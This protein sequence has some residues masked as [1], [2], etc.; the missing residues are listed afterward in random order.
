VN[1]AKNQLKVFFSF[2][3]F[4]MSLNALLVLWTDPYRVWNQSWVLKTQTHMNFYL[5]KF[6]LMPQS[7]EVESIILGASTS[8]NFVT[9]DIEAVF[10]GKAFHLSVAGS[11]TL[12]RMT[13]IR[14]AQQK[15]PN[16]KR[17]IY[18][19]DFYEFN[20][21][22]EDY[23]P[24]EVIDNDFLNKQ[25]PKLSLEWKHPSWVRHFWQLFSHVVIEKSFKQIGKAISGQEKFIYNKKGDVVAWSEVPAQEISAQSREQLK[26]LALSQQGDTI[27]PWL[28]SKIQESVIEYTTGVLK[29]FQYSQRTLQMYTELQKELTAKSIDLLIVASPWHPKF[30]KTVFNQYELQKDYEAWLT[31]LQ[32]LG[33]SSQTT[34]WVPTESH[35]IPTLKPHWRDGVHYSREVSGALLSQLSTSE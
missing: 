23:L 20:D 22:Y 28:S 35:P 30:K 12:G 18:I 10:G 34:V 6:E 14:L 15:F 21:N 1:L 32:S 8:E 3:F 7:H 31:D 4:I 33:L 27:S 19:S 11:Q 17:V 29:D 5:R 13:L 16:L 24:P 26:V 2:L 25:R 9:Q